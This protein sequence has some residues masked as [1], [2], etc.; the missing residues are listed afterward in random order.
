MFTLISTTSNVETLLHCFQMEVAK[1]HGCICLTGLAIDR[2]TATALSSL[3]GIHAQVTASETLQ[4][5]T[6]LELDSCINEYRPH[7]TLVTKEELAACAVSRSDLLQE[8]QRLDPA[9]F[10][11]VGIAI[12]DMADGVYTD[13]AALT[14]SVMKA[15]KY[16][17]KSSMRGQQGAMQASTSSQMQPFIGKSSK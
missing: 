7:A 6:A 11:P 16:S 13:T 12:V 10:F 2:I 17:T 3:H 5:Q 15:S 4:Q 14:H 9:A 1:S 8:F